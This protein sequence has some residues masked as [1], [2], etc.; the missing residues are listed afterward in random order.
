MSRLKVHTYNFTTNISLDWFSKIPS[1][2]NQT[3]L[4]TTDMSA[5]CLSS[6]SSN[7]TVIKEGRAEIYRSVFDL[8]RKKETEKKPAGKS[9]GNLLT[10]NLLANQ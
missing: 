9:S 5:C 8:R 2:P 3:V 10:R 6:T 7:K 4:L 1:M